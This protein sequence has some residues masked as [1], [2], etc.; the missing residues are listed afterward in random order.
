MATIQTVNN[1]DDGLTARNKIN[2]NDSNLNAEVSANTTKLATIET[3]A[4]ADQTDA[5]IETAYSNRVPQ[6][7]T[8]EKTGR[9]E[10]A[11]R[12]FSPKDVADMV[13]AITGLLSNLTT[14]DKT[15]LVAAI[16][17]LKASL[18]GLDYV[19]SY[20]ELGAYT[21]AST[22]VYV[23]NRTYGGL[24]ERDDT[25]VATTN[26]QGVVR[27]GTGRMWKR[28]FTRESV[29]VNWWIENEAIDGSALV[30]TYVQRAVDYCE[31]NSIKNIDF[32]GSYL[33]DAMDWGTPGANSFQFRGNGSTITL[34]YSGTNEYLFVVGTGGGFSGTKITG[35]TFIGTSAT[36]ATY[37]ANTHRLCKIN[38]A[39]YV[40]IEDCSFQ[41]FTSQAIYVESVGGDGTLYRGFRITNCIFEDQPYDSLTTDQAAIY[42][43]SATEYSQIMNCHFQDVVQCVKGIDAANI[44]V[45][46]NIVEDLNGPLTSGGIDT[47]R[48]AFYFGTS[49]TPTNNGKIKIIGNKINHI[50][51]AQLPIIVVGTNTGNTD[52]TVTIMANE[53]LSNGYFPAILLKDFDN[54]MIIGNHLRASNVSQATSSITLDGVNGAIVIGNNFNSVRYCV[55][56]QNSSDDLYFDST[57]NFSS[58]LLTSGYVE[59]V[60]GSL[61][62]LTGRETLTAI[63]GETQ[64]A[65]TETLPHNQEEISVYKNGLKLFPTDDYTVT[66]NTS[67]NRINFVAALAASDKI[68]VDY[69]RQRGLKAL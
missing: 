24:F 31:A 57:N 62:K 64:L 65:I 47:T 9:T 67:V 20:T 13:D 26:N 19:S 51:T 63:G 25:A 46:H 7:S 29:H 15:N 11:V 18:S 69:T 58:T 6:V 68:I 2:Q 1:G 49:A 52:N 40:N 27:T 22:K 12:R 3:G 37:T 17:E 36:D 66:S 50:N 44:D 56:L 34:N 48:A 55:S 53:C 41:Q 45:S 42:L 14:T 21:G 30:T 39:N 54:P 61:R 38:G 28:V 4:T 8:T 5:E 59:I 16:N 10:L 33:C 32:H 60:S 23:I 43:T 35:F